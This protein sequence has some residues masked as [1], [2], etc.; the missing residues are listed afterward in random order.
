MTMEKY[1]VSDRK[2]LQETELTQVKARIKEL[3]QSHEKTASETQEFE[4]L[5][6]RKAELLIA[7]ADDQ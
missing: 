1:A 7:L 4:R 3:G 5:D 6:Q 2:E